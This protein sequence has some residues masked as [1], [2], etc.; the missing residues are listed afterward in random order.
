MN[1]SHTS[2]SN[3]PWRENSWSC[4]FSVASVSATIILTPPKP[5]HDMAYQ[6]EIAQFYSPTLCRKFLPFLPSLCH[7]KTEFITPSWYR[8]VRFLKTYFVPFTFNRCEYSLFYFLRIAFGTLS[9]GRQNLSLLCV[10]VS[11]YMYLTL[12]ILS[13]FIYNINDA[14]VA[15]LSPFCFGCLILSIDTNLSS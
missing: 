15:G 3:I 10:L 14:F 7:T 4:E 1:E 5:R 12:S 2:C 11:C 9:F 13:F 6:Q 8:V